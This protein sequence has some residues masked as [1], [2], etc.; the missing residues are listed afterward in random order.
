MKKLIGLALA[1]G[2]V[3][4]VVSC[5]NRGKVIAKVG[6]QKIT[7]G[8]FD[9]S[10]QAPVTPLDSATAMTAKRRMLDQM[11][12]QKLLSLEALARNLDKEPKL[13]SEYETMKKN[14]LMGQL[15]RQEIME[16]SQPTDREIKDFYKKMGTEIKARHIL[17]KTEEEANV[18]YK[19]LK[20]GASFEETARQR[21]QDPGSASRGGD[22]GWFGWGRMVQAFQKAAFEIKPGQLGKPVKTPFGFHIIMVDSARPAEIK[23]FDQMKDMIKQQ[24]TASKPREMA[25]EY[26]DKIKSSAR[27]KI[28]KEVLALLAAKQP[29]TQ[30]PAPLPP[31]GTDEENKKTIV[32]YSGGSWTVAEFYNK[33][34]K[35]FGGNAD[36]RNPEMLQQQV[37]AMM[38]EDLLLARAKSKNVENDP[39]VKQQMEKAWDEMLSTALYQAEVGPR[40]SVSPESVKV[41]YALHKKEFYQPV[42]AVVSQII[43]RTKPEAEAVFKLLS[44]GADFA[45]TASEKSIDWTKSS[46]GALGEVAQNDPR[47]PEISK[48]AFA[49]ALNQASRPF[50]VKDG[51]AVIKVSARNP[52][53]QLSFE[54][55][56]PAI[57]QNMSQGQEQILY[58]GLIEALKT[59][60]PVTVNEDILKIAGQQKPEEGK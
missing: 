54:E 53:K 1:L 30:G 19:S 55:M 2:L 33:I 32:T 6:N 36:F 11:V 3:L 18:V 22:L 12:E 8:Q 48:M 38:V 46:G 13:L 20:D 31:L 58:L 28:N 45:A 41:Y 21:S 10:Y 51:F 43:T 50:A 59:K 35:M 56:K 29:M 34:N 40:V 44:Q 9:D 17:V 52:A 15:Y 49:I 42:K 24:L 14:M 16:K 39:K 37:E 57:E 27:I 47:Y 7:L 60:Y 23:P 25:T 26:V 5:G 4:S